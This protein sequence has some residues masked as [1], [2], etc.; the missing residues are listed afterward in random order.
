MPAPGSSAFRCAG[1]FLYVKEGHDEA[2]GYRQGPV[3]PDSAFC[4]PVMTRTVLALMVFAVTVAWFLW[5]RNATAA[6]A[7]AFA[8]QAR[9]S[10]VVEPHPQARN[11]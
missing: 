5:P 4:V 6:D 8:P 1:L 11:W 10:V 3:R 2:R 7:V 9:E